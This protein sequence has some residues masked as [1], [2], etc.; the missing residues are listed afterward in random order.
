MQE[1]VYATDKV[2]LA[3]LFAFAKVKI[4]VKIKCKDEVTLQTRFNDVYEE[5]DTDE[6]FKMAACSV[7]LFGSILTISS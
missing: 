6:D 5:G 3:Q 2:C 7:L 4:I 1:I